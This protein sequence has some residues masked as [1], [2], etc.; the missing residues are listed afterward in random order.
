MLIIKLLLYR[1]LLFYYYWHHHYHHCSCPISLLAFIIC[2]N[3]IVV[4]AI[5]CHL[6]PSFAI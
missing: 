4:I 1:F 5:I 6:A 3:I 2:I